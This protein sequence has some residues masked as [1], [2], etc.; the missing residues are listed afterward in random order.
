MDA[1]PPPD[2]RVERRG[3][4]RLYKAFPVKVRGVNAGGEAFEASTVV[5]NISSTG[6]YLRLAENVDLGAKL[7]VAVTLSGASTDAVPAPT[8]VVKGEVLRVESQPD[9]MLGVAIGI[10]K[11]RFVY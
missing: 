3:K 2:A 11:R 9:A 10:T 6:I 8:V 1:K 7:L 5:D 4:P